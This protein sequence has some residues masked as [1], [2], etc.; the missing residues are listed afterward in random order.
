M[1]RQMRRVAYD[2]GP[3]RVRQLGQPPQVLGSRPGIGLTML[4]VPHIL[5]SDILQTHGRDVL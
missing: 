4:Y 3:A 1:G 5:P 2:D